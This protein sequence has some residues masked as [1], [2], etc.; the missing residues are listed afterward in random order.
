MSH[1]TRYVVRYILHLAEREH[2]Q[3]FT[4]TMARQLFIIA[5]TPYAHILGQ[6]EI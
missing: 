6:W 2:E 3:E 5:L 4:N 1:Q